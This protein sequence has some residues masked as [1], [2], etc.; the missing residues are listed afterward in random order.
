MAKKPS[1]AKL[2]DPLFQQRLAEA[3]STCF[4][5]HQVDYRRHQPS[6]YEEGTWRYKLHAFEFD[7]F[8][9]DGGGGGGYGGGGDGGG[10]GGGGC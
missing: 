9:S 2:D 1:P 8:G 5:R 7:G 3:R 6:K 10:G 4:R